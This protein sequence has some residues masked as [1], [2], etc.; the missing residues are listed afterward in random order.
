MEKFMFKCLLENSYKYRVNSSIETHEQK[1]EKNSK[2]L[3][4]N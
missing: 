3:L 1:F 2:K 4:T